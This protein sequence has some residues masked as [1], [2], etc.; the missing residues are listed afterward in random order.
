M[1]GDSAYGSGPARAVLAD[2]GHTAVIK[3]IPL[4]PAVPG[5]FTA[6]DFTID[7]T[8]GTVTCPAGQTRQI[9]ASGTA[10]F[11]APCRDCPL[12]ARCTANTRGRAVK[13]NEHEDLLRAARRPAVQPD[14]QQLY[15]SKRPL[16]ERA[17]AWL[18]RGGNRRLRY[19]GV[20]KNHHRTTA[21]AR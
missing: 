17:I 10:T 12:R 18:V 3:P 2:A 14:H 21:P 7:T 20:A 15:R 1:L 4:R 9:T 8:T 16:V 19:R 6:D 5:G 13:V 11:G